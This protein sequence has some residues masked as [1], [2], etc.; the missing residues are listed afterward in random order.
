MSQTSSTASSITICPEPSPTREDEFEEVAGSYDPLFFDG[1]SRASSVTSESD[2]KATSKAP[3][4]GIDNGDDGGGLS[5]R[6][7]ESDSAHSEYEYN[8]IIETST[9]AK[10]DLDDEEPE[11]NERSDVV[12]YD[13]PP[14][15]LEKPSEDVG[16]NDTLVDDAEKLGTYDDPFIIGLSL[17]WDVYGLS[18]EAFTA[19]KQ[20]SSLAGP[21]SLKLLPESLVVLH[22]W[23][24]KRLPKLTL[25]TKRVPVNLVA[26][27]AGKPTQADPDADLHYFDPIELVSTLLKDPV[28][29]G[30]MY[31]GL[32]QIV[33]N[34]R[35][36]YHTR[37]WGESIVSSSGIYFYYQ[38]SKET[39]I[40]P[41]EADPIF[42]GDVVY[43][44]GPQKSHQIGLVRQIANNFLYGSADGGVVAVIDEILPR[45]QLVPVIYTKEQFDSV[46]DKLVG[47]HFLTQDR[48]LIIPIVNLIQRCRCIFDSPPAPPPEPEKPKKTPA[49]G[50]KRMATPPPPRPPT[51]PF[52]TVSR[53]PDCGN[54]EHRRQLQSG[55]FDFG[56][57]GTFRDTPFH[58][59][60]RQLVTTKQ[61]HLVRPVYS[62]HKVRGEHEMQ[63]FGR[64]Y[65]VNKFVRGN[66][67]KVY[68]MPSMT[69]IDGFGLFGKGT[70]SYYSMLGVYMCPGNFPLHMRLSIINQFPLVLGSMGMELST[71]A[72]AI[73]DGACSL[74]NGLHI[75]IRGENVLICAFDLAKIGETHPPIE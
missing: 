34:E 24:E 31:F 5:A 74:A 56:F 53:P 29:S 3:G 59:Y 7:E 6:E 1:S 61:S 65:L 20:L 67:K 23:N 42:Q 15:F 18:R 26:Q 27:P 4:N 9:S 17:F 72:D 35:E 40:E 46:T 58:F 50:K 49:K 19:F 62:R 48:P 13:I 37:V 12:I 70:A 38:N 25:M 10:E 47:S 16:E 51:R 8:E 68:V 69:F 64:E 45:N 52:L 21:N 71:V 54:P 39:G 30:Q 41:R 63:I 32:Q 73:A 60:V 14:G 28:I 55:V 44:R 33:P 22:K 57:A 11:V 43:F 75:K 2:D 36:L 66:H